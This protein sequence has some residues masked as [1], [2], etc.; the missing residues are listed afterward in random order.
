MLGT[1]KNYWLTI[2]IVLDAAF[3]VTL[4]QNWPDGDYCILQ[5][6]SSVCPVGFRFENIRLSVLQDFKL[7]QADE[8]GDPLIKLG[9][10]GASKLTAED[11]DNVY[12]L[13]LNVCCKD[14]TVFDR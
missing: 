12:S 6:E 7:E 1:L 9:R 11:Y 4:Q 2:I 3:L 5:G 10:I 13:H 14:E 8:H